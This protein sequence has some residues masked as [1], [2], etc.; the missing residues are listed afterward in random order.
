[1]TTYKPTPIDDADD[2]LCV[3]MVKAGVVLQARSNF[4][5]A[6][7]GVG[8]DAPTFKDLTAQSP[9]GLREQC[10]GMLA[11][12]GV[13]A[14]RNDLTDAA[15]MVKDAV[16]VMVSGIDETLDLAKKRD[17]KTVGDHL[18]AFYGKQ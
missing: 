18:A 2:A 10:R 13:M 5:Q 12:V 7:V 16:F 1:M 3:T 14:E 8:A 15:A 4:T 6:C 11:L 9:R 17:M